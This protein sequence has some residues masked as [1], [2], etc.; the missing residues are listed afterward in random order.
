MGVFQPVKETPLSQPEKEVS[1]YKETPLSQ[2][3]KEIPADKETQLSKLERETQVLQPEKQTLVSLAAEKYELDQS[4]DKSCYEESP[5]QISPQSNESNQEVI[6]PIETGIIQSTEQVYKSPEATD[7]N[8]QVSS[9][10]VKSQPL[11]IS[12]QNEDSKD[13]SEFV[14]TVQF[15]VKNK[16]TED[17]DGKQKEELNQEEGWT[18]GAMDDTK[19]ESDE[20]ELYAIQN[21][22]KTENDTLDENQ[23]MDESIKEEEEINDFIQKEFALQE[24]ENAELKDASKGLQNAVR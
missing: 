2:A 17:L 1:A 20:E 9:T 24:K 19:F 14:V 6:E 10:P 7:S 18:N 22:I 8:Q 16:E 4:V 13:N 12:F 23:E 15:N 5:V 21:M 11:E 3:E